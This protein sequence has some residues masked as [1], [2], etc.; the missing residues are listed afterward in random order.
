MLEKEEKMT[1]L[2]V[3]MKG[4]ASDEIKVP[5]TGTE[6]YRFKRWIMK[7]NPLITSIR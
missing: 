1:Y 7:C 4:G 2:Y 5:Y 3:I 6:L